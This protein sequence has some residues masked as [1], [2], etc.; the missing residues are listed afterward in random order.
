MFGLM[1][2][3]MAGFFLCRGA[4]ERLVWTL[5]EALRYR[6]NQRL[7]FMAGGRGSP[8]LAAPAR[9]EEVHLHRQSERTHHSHQEVQVHKDADPDFGMIAD[10]LGDRM[11][12][13]L[14]QLP[15]SYR[16]TKT[17]LNDIVSQLWLG[18][19]GLIWIRRLPALHGDPVCNHSA[20]RQRQCPPY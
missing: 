19:M 15:P 9:K 1:V 10:I 6:R 20:D 18:S 17:R 16:Y 4:A 2:L 5:R 3:E 12:C 13:F 14:F 7:L 11:G 8:G